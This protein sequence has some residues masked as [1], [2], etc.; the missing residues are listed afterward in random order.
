LEYSSAVNEVGFSL[1][2]RIN[3]LYNEYDSFIYSG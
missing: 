3:H 1:D 2:R